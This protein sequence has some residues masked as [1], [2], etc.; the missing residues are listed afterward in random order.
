[1][2]KMIDNKFKY[3]ENQSAWTIVLGLQIYNVKI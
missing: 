3:E 1:M 2:S